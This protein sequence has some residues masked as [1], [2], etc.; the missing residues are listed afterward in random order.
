MLTFII[1]RKLTDLESR[2]NGQLC[3]SDAVPSE[4]STSAEDVE[5][6]FH[7]ALSAL[8]SGPLSIVEQEAFDAV[9]TAVRGQEQL[10]QG[11]V[12][13][14]AKT[15]CQNLNVLVTDG[16]SELKV[17][18]RDKGDPV[19]AE[20]RSSVHAY[21]YFLHC[22][23]NH[24]QAEE[25]QN[26]KDEAD[27]AKKGRGKGRAKAKNDDDGEPSSAWPGLRDS[28]VRTF[29]RT[30]KADLDGVLYRSPADKFRL[31]EVCVLTAKALLG[32]F[33]ET[34]PEAYDEIQKRDSKPVRQAAQMVSLLAKAVPEAVHAFMSQLEPYFGCQSAMLIRSHLVQS[35]AHL[36][37]YYESRKINETDTRSLHISMHNAATTIVERINDM[38]ALV[39]KEALANIQLLVEDSC[40]PN[41]V[42]AAERAVARLDDGP[43]VAGAAL[44][45]L[46][47]IINKWADTQLTDTYLLEIIKTQ[48]ERLQHMR[49]DVVEDG[50]EE[51]GPGWEAGPLGGEDGQ[52]A[53]P[54][55]IEAEGGGPTSQ[56]PIIMPTQIDGRPGN[57][58]QKD[59]SKAVIAKLVGMVG[60]MALCDQEA[61]EEL[62]RLS[63][64][65]RR[66]PK[67]PR[68]M[69]DA[70]LQPEELRRLLRWFRTN[71]QEAAVLQEQGKLE[72]AQE[73]RQ[74]AGRLSILC[75]MVAR[76]APEYAVPEVE[77]LVR[78]LKTSHV[79]LKDAMLVR[80]VA[81]ML[82]DLAPALLATHN[83]SRARTAGGQPQPPASSHLPAALSNLLSVLVSTHL[84][85][86]GGSWEPA[87]QAAIAAI[88]RL[89]P[90]PHTLMEPLLQHL[91][92]TVLDGAGSCSAPQLARAL[93]IVGCVATQQLAFIDSGAKRV[94]R[95]R[96][97]KEKA[98]AEANTG[99]PAADDMNAQLGTGQ[100]REHALDALQEELEAELMR[101]GGLLGSWGK[102][103]SGV[104]HDPALLAADPCLASSAMS[105]LAKLMVLDGAFC[106]ANCRVFFTRLLAKG[107]VKL[108]SAVRCGMLVALGDLGRRHPNII[109]PWTQ[110][111]FVCLRDDDEEVAKTCLRIL[112][113]LILSDMTKPK[114]HM[115]HVARCLVARSEALRELAVRL[116]NSL[117]SK[118][119]K[120]GANK[121]YQYLPEII[122]ESTR[123][124]PMADQDFRAMM[125]A[126]NRLLGYIKADK[127]ADS[128]KVRICERFENV[129][130]EFQAAA[131]A[132][133]AASATGSSGG[134]YS[135]YEAVVRE[136]RGLAVCLDMLP[137][138]EKGLRSVMETFRRY[139][140][141][142]GDKHVYD[143]FKDMA[144]HGRQS[145]RTNE[146]KAEVQEWEARLDEAYASLQE[147]QRRQEA[148]ATAARE[149]AAAAAT[150][151]A[152]AGAA[153]A[154]AEGQAEA[155]AQSGDP[156]ADEDMDEG[157]DEECAQEEEEQLDVVP[158]VAG[159][160][161]ER[162]HTVGE[163]GDD[164]DDDGEES[165]DEYEDA[166]SS[167]GA[168]G[169]ED[170]GPD[171][172]DV[173]ED[174][175]AAS[176][177][178]PL[179]R[180]SGRTRGATVADTAATPGGAPRAGTPMAI[181][182]APQQQDGPSGGDDMAWSPAPAAAAAAAAAAALA[183]AAQ[184]ENVAPVPFGGFRIKPDPGATA[185]MPVGPVL[186]RNVLGVRVKPDPDGPAR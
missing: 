52:H 4:S 131:T 151:A 33:C 167:E 100:A 108:P 172:M 120:G 117:A 2:R 92:V 162:E 35:L 135:V 139:K 161:A 44:D 145:N 89:H 66:H 183:A 21:A 122:S 97:A 3:A 11:Q 55:G 65:P 142:L 176:A 178:T 6:S 101:E 28:V 5:A 14:L 160:G 113:H 36:M 132:E 54:T 34:E 58:A 16:L 42:L 153:A 124:D 99:R 175:P 102:L 123:G 143:V 76:H 159:E 38:A 20:H 128:L 116:F 174:A 104:C 24:C 62:M 177:V 110:S 8:E 19:V 57:S 103:V 133:G 37:R 75:T 121:V 164:D 9:Y 180:R 134:L 106:E 70:V 59:R 186:G 69:Y 74:V 80:N 63:M 149:A 168:E 17:D 127:L 10:T 23:F 85:A 26:K 115:V 155:D 40:W 90:E 118:Q 18:E 166:E 64:R 41:M 15:L 49:P 43:M 68:V 39:R 94:R 51:E 156:A 126:S 181:T 109:E 119:A 141:A 79:V 93:F 163:G 111:M 91:A 12:Q 78:I 154:A 73:R 173:D 81:T 31:L 1:P 165:G 96:S 114:G 50:D 95:E 138:S 13:K 150:A 129:V 29:G 61:L 32:K 53:K 144:K 107:K 30:L 56:L 182:P 71:V 77:H 158:A 136:W 25:L 45:L 83:T 84:P 105:A 98:A 112:A 47:Q 169:E 184:Q 130:C 87:A 27:G 171:G 7:D 82:G 88:Y 46:L 60:D 72:D 48:E 137:Y 140:H 152:E 179:G 157:R 67:D 22:V 147:E 170:E 125:K 185:G 148:A 86:T 146:L